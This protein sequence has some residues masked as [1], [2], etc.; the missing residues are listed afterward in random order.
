MWGVPYVGRG[1]PT[2]PPP[3]P[4]RPSPPAQAAAGP[5]GPCRCARPDPA[6]PPRPAGEGAGER[7]QHRRDPPTP[8]PK[9]QPH[10]DPPPKKKNQPS[11]MEKRGAPLGVPPRR[12]AQPLGSG[13]YLHGGPAVGP[14]VSGGAGWEVLELGAAPLLR[15]G[16]GVLPPAA[17]RHP[18][19]PAPGPAFPA[20]WARVGALG[21]S[22]PSPAPPKGCWGG[23]RVPDVPNVPMSPLPA[24]EL[25]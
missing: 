8:T 9:P 18:Q 25:P 12:G 13:P 22:R 19:V 16:P 15:G 1:L 10:G 6:A 2:Q 21:G 3:R 11:T 14:G 4:Y 24:A 7:C 5:A 23:G 17:P 20:G